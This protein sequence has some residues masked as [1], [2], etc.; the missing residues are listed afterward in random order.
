MCFI[1]DIILQDGGQNISG[2][3]ILHMVYRMTLY[4]RRGD[5]IFQ[6]E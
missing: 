5:R 6:V 1:G 4:F 2:T 3:V